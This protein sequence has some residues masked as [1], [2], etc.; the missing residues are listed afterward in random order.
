M[1]PQLVNAVNQPIK[2]ALNFPAAILQAPNFDPRDP[3]SMNFGAT[4]A[5]IGHK[6]SHSFD[7]QG[8]RR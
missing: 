8:T 3:A 4:G 7:D 1:T 2:N 5:T 6:I